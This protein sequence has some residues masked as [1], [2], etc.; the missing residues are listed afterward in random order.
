MKTSRRLMLATFLTLIA[1][2]VVLVAY[3]R[4]SGA[5]TMTELP[6]PQRTS[7]AELAALRDFSSIFIGGDVDVVVRSAAN[8]AISY[9]PLF[10]RRGNLSA[11]VEDGRLFI[12]AY[13]NRSETEAARLE[14]SLPTLTR[15]E[16]ESL[17]ALTVSGFRADTLNVVARS[18]QRVVIEDNALETLRL[19]LGYVNRVEQRRNTI[20]TVELSHFGAT[21]Q[22]E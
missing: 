14:I 19:E 15:V 6:A 3:G 7:A 20:G 1:S 18:A 22:I 17:F 11:R 13:G 4:I 10:E 16:G 12:E 9:T 21:I 5:G 2:P 8:Y